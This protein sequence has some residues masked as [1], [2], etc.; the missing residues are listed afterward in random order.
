MEDNKDNIKDFANELEIINDLDVL[1]SKSVS[2]FEGDKFLSEGIL[3]KEGNKLSLKLPIRIEK[4]CLENVIIETELGQRIF[5][6]L[7]VDVRDMK[8]GKD[9][10]FSNTLC[11][12]RYLREDTFSPDF[13]SQFRCFIPTSLSKLNTYRFQLE[14]IRYS[15]S[16]KIYSAQCVRI[17][18]EDLQFNVLQIKQKNEG[19]YV[20]EAFQDMSFDDFA[21]YCYAIQQALGFVMGY[22]PGGEIFY[23]SG[24]KDYYYTNHVRP[25]MT[26][27]YYP[28]HTNPYNFIQFRKTSAENY[29][30]KLNVMSAK[31]FS[32]LVSLIYS[33]ERFSSVVTMMIESESIR[34]LLLIPSI[35]AIILES[36]SKI[37]CT[38]IVEEKKPIKNKKLFQ[39][40]LKELESI[41]D[42]YSTEFESD[43]DV[44]K[45]RRR[46]SELNKPIKNMKQL[47]NT[48]KLIQ[49]FEQLGIELTP[50]DI[51]MIEHRNDLLHGN[52]HLANSTRTETCDINNYMMYASGKLYTLISSLILKYVGYS[53]Y[54]I[55]HAKTCEKYCNINT[56]ED[57]YK[58]I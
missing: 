33:N 29:L 2:V 40:I 6:T 48:E 15:D 22:M 17:N 50:E 13:T 18:F 51:A 56:K 12:I 39:K 45:L 55:N 10:I 24:N 44:L 1:I 11:S 35:Y 43:D 54:I 41:I 42:S 20:I 25:A 46:L 37:V 28:I 58:Y 5:T 7:Y 8:V 53:G 34:S 9:G 23:F 38:P 57:Y 30:D 36:L 32:N 26:S 4:N 31:C 49:P 14:T 3:L 16:E 19:Y 27:L 52:T 47:S 21:N